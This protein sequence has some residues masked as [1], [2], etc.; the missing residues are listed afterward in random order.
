MD[1]VHNDNDFMEP[2]ENY[3]PEPQELTHEV[4][5]LEKPETYKIDF[6][7]QRTTEIIRDNLGFHYYK[8]KKTENKIYLVCLEKKKQKIHVEQLL[9]YLLTK[10]MINWFCVSN[11]NNAKI[12]KLKI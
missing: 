11:C 9:I 10:M 3:N 1:L 5:N 8:N 6:G 7:T 2:I 4:L 12:K